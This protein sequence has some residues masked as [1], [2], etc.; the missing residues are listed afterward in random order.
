MSAYP[1]FW[2]LAHLADPQVRKLIQIGT[3]D[4]NGKTLLPPLLNLSSEKLDRNGLF[5]LENGQEIFLWA[6]KGLASQTC[7][8]IFGKPAVEA[9]P[10]GKVM[11]MT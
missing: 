10:F 7:L 4:A 8:D 2:D 6:G 1:R 5:L 9:L 3:K 11:I